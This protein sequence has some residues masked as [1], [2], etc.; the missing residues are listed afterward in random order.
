[1]VIVICQAGVS[2]GF[3]AV[4]RKVRAVIQRV[5]ATILVL[6]VSVWAHMVV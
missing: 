2:R 5:R 6:S 3:W 1:M 4:A